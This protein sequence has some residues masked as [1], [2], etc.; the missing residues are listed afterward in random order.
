MALS[1]IEDWKEGDKL[2]HP[3]YGVGKVIHIFGTNK[4]VE[5]LGVEFKDEFKN[6]RARNIDLN[7]F[8][9]KKLVEDDEINPNYN[10]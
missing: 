8:G 4:K 3:K 5:S 1:P 6:K 10:F 2:I 9:L 7:T